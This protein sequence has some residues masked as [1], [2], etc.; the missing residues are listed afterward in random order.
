[1]MYNGIGI[2]TLALRVSVIR[3]VKGGTATRQREERRL[4]FRFKTLSPEHFVLN[5]SRYNTIRKSLI[6]YIV[7]NYSDFSSLDANQKIIF[8]FNNIDAFLCKKL[9]YFIYEAFALRNE[10]TIA[11][12]VN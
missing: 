2:G 8:L 9:G 1:M 3:Q 6:D 7:R 11:T 5:C 4:I 12:I 10:S